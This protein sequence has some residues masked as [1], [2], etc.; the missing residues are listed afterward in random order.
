[1]SLAD[2][3]STMITTLTGNNNPPI[4]VTVNKAYSTNHVDITLPNGDIIENVEASGRGVTNTTALF[5]QSEN[6]PFVLLFED[7][8]TT[9]N[10][11]GLGL[12][13]INDGDLYLELPIG[14]SNN[15]NISD[16]D[17]TVT[18]LTGYKIVN[19]NLTYERWDL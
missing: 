1:M 15:F 10:S 6:K 12:F 14:A 16:G 8:T 18:D 19:N 4:V 13:Y 2:E 5:I 11:L 7:A 9:I 3:I 17:L